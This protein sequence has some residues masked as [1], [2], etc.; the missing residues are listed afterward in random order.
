MVKADCAKHGCRPTISALER[1]RRKS[2]SQS[3][4]DYMAR[5]FSK[6]RKERGRAVNECAVS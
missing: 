4:R 1:L 5:P 6:G 2:M 3:S